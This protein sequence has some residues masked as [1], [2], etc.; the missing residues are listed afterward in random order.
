MHRSP[1]FAIKRKTC[2]YKSINQRYCKQTARLREKLGCL[3]QSLKSEQLFDFLYN[4]ES[5]YGRCSHSAEQCKTRTMR[6]VLV[7]HT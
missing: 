3:L 5:L 4:K 2:G 7:L 6:I 1:N